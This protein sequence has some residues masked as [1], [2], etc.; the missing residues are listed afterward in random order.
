MYGT[1]IRHCAHGF[2]KYEGTRAHV[3]RTIGT[4]GTTNIKTPE[5]L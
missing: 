1:W 5:R 3:L 4:I 2:E